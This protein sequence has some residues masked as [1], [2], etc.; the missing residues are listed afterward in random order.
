MVIVLWLTILARKKSIST[1]SI[2]LQN[3]ERVFRLGE[4]LA[5]NNVSKVEEL[6]KKPTT[7]KIS[8]PPS[9]PRHVFSV[10]SRSSAMNGLPPTKFLD[11]PKRNAQDSNIESLIQMMRSGMEVT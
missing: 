10:V 8:P 7:E 2:Y 4:V 6:A 11:T 9:P 5:S 3:I 1:N